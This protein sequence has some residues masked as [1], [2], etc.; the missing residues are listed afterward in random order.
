MN[1]RKIEGLNIALVNLSGIGDV[2]SSLSVG[3]PLSE[4]NKV[5]YIIPKAY[6]GLLSDSGFEEKASDSP[7]FNRFDIVIDLTSNKESR[8]LIKSISAKYKIGRYKN[9]IQKLKYSFLY[10]KMVEKFPSY[11]NIIMDYKPIVDLFNLHFSNIIELQ[12][13]EEEIKKEIIIHIGA[14]KEI[15]RIPTNLIVEICDY[16]K[17][18]NITVRLVGTEEILANEILS[19][20]KKYPV[21]EK[22]SL[23]DVKSWLNESSLIIAP[24][25]GIF[26]LGSAL[27]KKAIGLYGPNTSLRAGV[28]SVN[29]Q[30]LELD[31]DC[32]PC[33]QNITC[34]YNNKCMNDIPFNE[35]KH[36][37]DETFGIKENI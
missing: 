24:D 15:R 35:L 16:S 13:L 17:Q 1:L 8:K 12:S 32:R 2:I 11:D 23:K 25:S 5:T 20:T 14:D 22:G 3:S 29:S 7:N 18:N 21:Y 9:K 4:K 26:H 37:I 28:K 33:N 10:N 36:S 6:Q 31:Y 27:G 34:P 19:R 30:H